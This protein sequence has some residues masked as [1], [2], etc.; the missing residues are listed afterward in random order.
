VF[1]DGDNRVRCGVGLTIEPTLLSLDASI[2]NVPI[3]QH[4]S[5]IQFDGVVSN[6]LMP[7]AKVSP[8]QALRSC[9]YDFDL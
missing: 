4:R 7:F 8:N 1:R 3:K 9:L 5:K 6:I 2:A